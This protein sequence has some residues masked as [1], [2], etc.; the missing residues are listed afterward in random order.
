LK[1]YDEA[2]ESKSIVKVFGPEDYNN[3]KS[4]FRPNSIQTFV[5]KASGV[6]DFAFGL[7][8]HYLWDATSAIVDPASGR[9]A[10]V[11]AAYNPKSKDYYEVC[12]IAAKGLSLMSTFMPGYPYP[13]PRMTVFNG[14]DGMEFPMM[15]ND[16]STAPNSPLTLTVHE[17]SHTYFP[18]MMGI[19]EQYYA[20]MDEGWAAF[21][22]VVVSDSLAGKPVGRMRNYWDFA[23]TE[24]DMPPMTPSRHLSNPAYRVASYNRPQ[25]AY[26]ALYQ[27][28]G[29]ERF[30]RCM[31]TYMDRW[32]GKHPMPYDFFNTWNEVSGQNL[33]WFWKPWF[34]DWGYPDLG[35]QGVDKDPATNRDLILIDRLGNLPTPV[36]LELTYEDGST[37]RLHRGADVWRDGK[38]QLAIPAQ[39]GKPLKSLTLG[40]PTV[41]DTDK[42]NNVW[43]K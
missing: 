24:N 36:Y 6:P 4:F 19:N 38:T 17:S 42:K 18:F 39:T 31:V 35:I 15:C 2:L 5:Y 27:M 22:D 11:S 23:G 37:E 14:D 28:L 3:K 41:P 9:K 33:N 13:Y 29:Y 20:W 10:L 43:S 16:G 1:R 25:A 30:H 34:F 8:D 32:K 21:F 12:D 7:S 26:F 40:A